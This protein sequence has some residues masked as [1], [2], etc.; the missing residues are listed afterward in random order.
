MNIR[1]VWI[2]IK[3]ELRSIFRDKKSTI[4]VLL[5][6]LLIPIMIVLIGTMETNMLVS[7]YKNKIGVN[8]ELTDVEKTFM[9]SSMLEPIFYENI[10]DMKSAYENEEITAYITFENDK[11][12]VYRELDMDAKIDS[13]LTAYFDSYNSYLKNNYLMNNGIDINEI[14]LNVEYIDTGKGFEF[15]YIVSMTFGYIVML[16]SSAVCS[17]VPDIT[18]GEKERG[19]MET[20]LTFPL[21]SIDIIMGKYLAVSIFSIIISLVSLLL[22]CISI[23][24]L[25][26]L[27]SVFSLVKFNTDIITLLKAVLI[28]IVFSLFISA[29]TIF[30]CGNRKTFKEAQSALTIVQLITVF[31]MV[32]PLLDIKSVVFSIIPVIGHSQLLNDLF[33][34][35]VS[36]LSLLGMFIS[37]IIYTTILI[38]LITRQYKSERVLF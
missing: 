22:C 37:T 11:Y 15:A 16:V 18:A 10:D 19:T 14:D 32:L 8:Y 25:V 1:M 13:L 12:S 23:K 6:P 21:K 29:L 20:L 4:M 33:V 28:C 26:P 17:I 7:D 31:S 3:K 2:T 34:S 38:S 27:Y 5:L 30:T 9:D 35:S 36:V 24:F